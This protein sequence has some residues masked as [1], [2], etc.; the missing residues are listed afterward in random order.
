MRKSLHPSP[1]GATL[2]VVVMLVLIL[3]GLVGSLMVYAGGER[4]RAVSHARA[5]QRQSCAESGLQLARSYFGRNYATWNTFLSAPSS[6]DP[7]P[8]TFNPTPADPESP[9][10]LS[11]H[12][13]LFADVDGDGKMDVFLYIRDNE[14]E[15]DPLPTNWRRDNDQVAVVGA[16]CIS[17]TLRPRRN[18]GS[19]DAT[20][21]ALEGLLSYNG[22]GGTNCSQGNAGTGAGNCN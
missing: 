6:Y 19:Q 17:K 22:G 13:E 18:D 10:L 4:V 2:L 12:P 1:R 3:L 9:A 14:D 15:F 21:L 20:T 16:I 5:G 11:A 7:V 8:S